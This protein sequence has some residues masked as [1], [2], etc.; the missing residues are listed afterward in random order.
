MSFLVALLVN[1]YAPNFC[2]TYTHDPMNT[3]VHKIGY[4][5]SLWY[6]MA[7]TA[8]LVC[9][10]YYWGGGEAEYKVPT[11]TSHVSRCNNDDTQDWG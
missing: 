5:T 11:Y 1:S 3:S 8:A 6:G 4:L 9:W 7:N 2:C 10:Y